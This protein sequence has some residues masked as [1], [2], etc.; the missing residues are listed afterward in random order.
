MCLMAV[1]GKFLKRDSIVA[2]MEL[3]LF[4]RDEGAFEIFEIEITVAAQNFVSRNHYCDEKTAL[5]NYKEILK[6]LKKFFKKY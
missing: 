6:K 4:R 1:R 2:G 3:T 5:N